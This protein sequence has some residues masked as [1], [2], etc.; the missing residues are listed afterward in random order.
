MKS[1]LSMAGKMKVEDRPTPF[2][3]DPFGDAWLLTNSWFWGASRCTPDANWN[4][5]VYSTQD[6]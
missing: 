3:S 6:Y 5:I 4:P 1:L 2:P